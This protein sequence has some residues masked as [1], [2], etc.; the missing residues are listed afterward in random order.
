MPQPCP[1]EEPEPQPAT[2]ID[3]DLEPA[4]PGPRR[5]QPRLPTLVAAVAVGGVI[6]AEARYG[7]GVALPHGPAQW[8]WATLLINISGCFLI[9]V[10]MVMITELVDAHPLI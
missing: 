1:G 6:G 10:L 2:N 3:P 9:G 7:L 5:R 8:P 4:D